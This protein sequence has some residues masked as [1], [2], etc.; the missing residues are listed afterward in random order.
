MATGKR[1]LANKQVA[2]PDLAVFITIF[3]H[4][5]ALVWSLQ[6]SIKMA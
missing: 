2:N 5:K 3:V 1:Q 6:G 4:F